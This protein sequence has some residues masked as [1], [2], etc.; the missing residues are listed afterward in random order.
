MSSAFASDAKDKSGRFMSLDCSMHW[1]DLAKLMKGLYPE[2]PTAEPF[3]AHAVMRHFFVFVWFCRFYRFLWCGQV[4][5]QDDRLG[6]CVD[7]DCEQCVRHVLILNEMSFGSKTL[8][9]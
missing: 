4:S 3:D 7:F 8:P 5:G 6:F 1:N 9:D 2:M